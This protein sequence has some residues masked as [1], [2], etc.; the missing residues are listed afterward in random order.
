MFGQSLKRAVVAAG[1]AAAM[2]IGLGASPASATIINAPFTWFPGGSVPPL[3]VQGPF[4]ADNITV[5]DFSK[6][7]IQ[8]GGVNNGQFTET[9]ILQI[10]A[11]SCCG[12][13]GG[14]ISTPGLNGTPAGPTNYKLYFT[15]SASGNLNGGLPWPT[16]GVGAGTA[17][18][19]FSGSFSTLTYSFFGDPSG[20]STLNNVGG[21]PT[22]TQG[23]GFP[24]VL[25][26][27]GSLFST[28]PICTNSVTLGFNNS[29]IPSP[30]AQATEDFNKAGGQGGFFIAP[31]LTLDLEDAFT[32]TGVGQV[33]V[34]PGCVP[35]AGSTSCNTVLITGGGGSADFFAIPEPGS[36][37]L[38]GSGLIGWAGA[39]RRRRARA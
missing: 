26:A 22:V 18:K 8:N 33:A 9:G 20:T 6:I 24:D 23:P 31:L 5:K 15:F 32:N 11:F 25:L 7:T 21:V 29:N 13:G 37:L 19:T 34:I 17:G 39:S 16:T 30:T 35:A 12:L 14:V 28:C 10:T 38:L 4:T 1:T 2:F 3:A 36:L 27:T